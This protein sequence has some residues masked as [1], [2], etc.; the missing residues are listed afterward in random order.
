MCLRSYNNNNK[1]LLTFSHR[2]PPSAIAYTDKVDVAA[3]ATYALYASSFEPAA[4]VLALTNV[5]AFEIAAALDNG[6]NT[7]ASHTHAAAYRQVA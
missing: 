2:V 6:F 3:P 1:I 4:Q 7:C 5:E